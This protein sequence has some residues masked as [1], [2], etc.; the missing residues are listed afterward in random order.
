MFF[1]LKFIKDD[2]FETVNVEVSN[3][4][5]LLKV[6]SEILSC[7]FDK[8]DGT[9]IDENNYLKTS[10]VWTNLLICISDK[11]DQILSFF[12]LKD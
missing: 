5:E 11:K 3:F 12:M 8:L 10:P 9:L 6:S 2:P 4:D 1:Y 7:T